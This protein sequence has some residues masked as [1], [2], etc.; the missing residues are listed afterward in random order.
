[1]E[2]NHNALKAI[3][4]RYEIL[5]ETLEDLSIHGRSGEEK[6]LA[7]G[8]QQ[9]LNKFETVFLLINFTEIFD[10]TTP[11]SKVW[12]SEDMDLAAAVNMAQE[13]I[14]VLK[15]RRTSDDHFNTIWEKAVKFAA[16]RNI[17]VAQQQ[18][19][20]SRRQRKPS[21]RLLGSIVTETIGQRDTSERDEDPINLTVKDVFT[22]PS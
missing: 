3:F 2:Y 16:G 20:S 4:K 22:I 15:D 17:T 7:Y 9:S 11:L 10:I 19:S 18:P 12:Q 14:K 6:A 8:L 5:T 1:M 13:T 21:S